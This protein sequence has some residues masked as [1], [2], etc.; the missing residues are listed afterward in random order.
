[1]SKCTW[2]GEGEYCNNHT[3]KGKHYCESH[4]WKIYQKDSELFTKHKKK[5][6][7]Q[8]V[9]FWELL[10]YQAVEELESEG[11]NPEED[12]QFE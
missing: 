2:I 10:F 5:K 12:Y 3:I 7:F 6:P 9:A 8:S 1:M 4:I 11:W